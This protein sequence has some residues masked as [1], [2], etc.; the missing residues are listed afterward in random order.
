MPIAR[1]IRVRLFR[2][3]GGRNEPDVPIN[4]FAKQTIAPYR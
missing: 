4:A 1:T 3:V 2:G